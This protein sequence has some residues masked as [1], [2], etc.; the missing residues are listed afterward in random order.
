MFDRDL[1]IFA[2]DGLISQLD[3]GGEL[4]IISEDNHTRGLIVRSPEFKA[5]VKA[6]LEEERRLANSKTA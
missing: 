5:R 2:L 1:I 6:F 4:L 3:S